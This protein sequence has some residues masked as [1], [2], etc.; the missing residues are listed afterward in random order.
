LVAENLAK[1]KKEASEAK[2]IKVIKAI[3]ARKVNGAKRAYDPTNQ[4]E[5]QKVKNRFIRT[6]MTNTGPIS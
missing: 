6:Y 4:W 1:V 5:V 2:V 3:K